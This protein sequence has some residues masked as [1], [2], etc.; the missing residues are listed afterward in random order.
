[1]VTSYFER[2]VVATADD[3]KARRSARLHAK[4]KY[5]DTPLKMADC[6]G[7]VYSDDI[8]TDTTE[9]QKHRN[10]H[11]LRAFLFERARKVVLLTL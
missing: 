5:V 2:S 7:S 1:M 3:V 10:K 11:K 9:K 4:H 6:I 8:T